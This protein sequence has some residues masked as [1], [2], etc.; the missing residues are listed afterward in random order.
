MLKK[1]KAVI[2]DFRDL[3]NLMKEVQAKFLHQESKPKDHLKPVH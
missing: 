2:K 1:A 3:P